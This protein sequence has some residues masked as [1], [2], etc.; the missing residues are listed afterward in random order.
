MDKLVKK[1]KKEGITVVIMDLEK[2][3][4]AITDSKI[5]FVNQSLDEEYQI[6]VTLHE[7]QHILEHS[8][9][10]ALYNKW[11]FHSKFENDAD[12]YVIDNFIEEN[13][14]EYNYSMLLEK[15]NIGIGYDTRYQR[16]AK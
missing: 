15:F 11:T 9:F 16:F 8:E 1:L 13:N 6:E 3:G 5:I 4:Y 10:I 14:R 2:E 12:S 7:L